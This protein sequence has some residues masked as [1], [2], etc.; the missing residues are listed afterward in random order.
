MAQQTEYTY[1][2]LYIN[3]VHVLRHYYPPQIISMGMSDRYLLI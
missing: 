2:V 3:Q 1:V